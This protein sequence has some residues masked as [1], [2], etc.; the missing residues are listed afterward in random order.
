MESSIIRRRRIIK[1][2]L[3]SLFFTMLVTVGVSLTSINHKT[4]GI[5]GE[6]IDYSLTLD[7]TNKVTSDGDRDQYSARGGKVTFT[8]S[9]VANSTTG[10]VT[11]NN[12]GTVVN[13][14]IIHSVT[15]IKAE[16]AGSLKARLGFV[17]NNWGEYF[18]LVSGKEYE[19]GT[20]PYFV[21]F[22]G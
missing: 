11:L 14:D 2:S 4:F 22:T 7:S 1:Y 20:N 8:Y 18:D 9:N 15:S 16:F 17:N 12:G 10:H 21:I 19:T 5:R 3:I 13:K 6:G